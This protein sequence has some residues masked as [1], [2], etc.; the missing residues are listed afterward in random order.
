MRPKCSRSGE[1]LVLA[2]QVR[3]ARIDQ[4]HAR[5]PVLPRDLLR[6]KLLLHR[7]GEVGATLHGGVVAHHHALDAGDAAD[8]GD[9]PRRGYLAAVHAVG[10]EE[11]D[12]QEGGARV[13]EPAHPLAR[14]E[15]AA[16]DVPGACALRPAFHDPGRDRGGLLDELS[17]PVAVGPEGVRAHGEGG[18]EDAHDVP[19]CVVPPAIVPPHVSGCCSRYSNRA[20]AA[21]RWPAAFQ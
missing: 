14:Q 10:G 12:F 3:P 11:A 6:A 7:Q 9:E 1:D 19:P 17:Q 21:H 2:R 20:S 8:A 5:K 16:F 15:L 13:E 18:V 4:V